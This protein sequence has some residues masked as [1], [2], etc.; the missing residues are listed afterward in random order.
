MASRREFLNIFKT[1]ITKEKEVLAVR[2]PYS[3]D[4]SLFLSECPSCENRE[5]QTHCEEEII[6]IQ[7]D[8]TPTL[9]FSKSG[10]TFCEECAKVC[11]HGV[12][13]LSEDMEE[14]I[15]AR[16]II[17]PD[18]CLAHNK[19]ICFSCKEP[20]I[21]DAILFNGMFN[22]IIDDERCTGCG[23]CISRCPTKAI[24]YEVIKKQTEGMDGDKGEVS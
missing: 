5:C 22:P 13:S 2:P 14:K 24:S 7:A 15:W 23:F 4:E 19:T 1:Q 20:C 8:K 3:K 21:D 16:F 10:C 11:P 17:E 6:V 9:N 12:L 18:S